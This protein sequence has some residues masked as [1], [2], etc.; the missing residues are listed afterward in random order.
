MIKMACTA[1]SFLCAACAFAG[2]GGVKAMKEAFEANPPKVIESAKLTFKGVD[3]GYDVYNC[4]IPFAW[5]GTEYIF[6]RVEPHDKWASSVTMLFRKTGKDEWTR[7]LEFGKLE[8]ED[9][10]IQYIRG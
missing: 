8:L 10:Y 5:G 4:S 3:E 2:D 7:V 1:V 6:G 9:P